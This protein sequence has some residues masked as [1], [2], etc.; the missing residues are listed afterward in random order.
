MDTI[1]C[2][3][4]II[5]RNKVREFLWTKSFGWLHDG[6]TTNLV[7][8]DFMIAKELVIK[9]ALARSVTVSSKNTSIVLHASA[10]HEC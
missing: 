2:A 8:V 9:Y 5:D 10:L 4:C 6:Y 7:S 1:L 3:V